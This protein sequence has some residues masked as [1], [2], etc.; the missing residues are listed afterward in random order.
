M[1]DEFIEKKKE[2]ADKQND[3]TRW[4]GKAYIIAFFF[5]RKAEAEK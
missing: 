5:G 3:I 4:S 1:Y 2:I